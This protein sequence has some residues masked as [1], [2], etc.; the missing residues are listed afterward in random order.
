M[1]LRLA[2]ALGHADIVQLL[3]THTNKPE[4]LTAALF[5][6]CGTCAPAFHNYYSAYRSVPIKLT[7][8]QQRCCRLLFARGGDPTDLPVDLRRE[9]ISAL[10]ESV[11]QVRTGQS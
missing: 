3:L 6:I 8:G 7:E 2:A 9:V 11:Q 1:P 4:Q 10:R 5:A